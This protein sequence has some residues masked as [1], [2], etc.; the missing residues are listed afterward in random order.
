MKTDNLLI[1]IVVNFYRE[2]LR[3]KNFLVENRRIEAL[4]EKNERV[5]KSVGFRQL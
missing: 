3:S 4:S 2:F 1:I 5:R